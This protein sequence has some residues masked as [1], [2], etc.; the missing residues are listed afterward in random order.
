MQDRYHRPCVKRSVALLLALVVS[1]SV[2]AQSSPKQIEVLLKDEI[3]SPAVAQF[4]VQQYLVE[5]AAKPPQAP[6]SAPQSGPPRLGALGI[7]FWKMSC[8]TV[9]PRSGSRHSRNS[10]R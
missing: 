10:K 3:M 6:A 1:P 9:G 2:W 4:Q 7:I 5:H 8:I